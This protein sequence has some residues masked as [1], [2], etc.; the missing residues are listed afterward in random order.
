MSVFLKTRRTIG[1]T[2]ENKEL[3]NKLRAMQTLYARID[4]D[5]KVIEDFTKFLIESKERCDTLSEFYENEWQ[6]VVEEDDSR[7]EKGFPSLGI[8]VYK[9]SE[10]NGKYSILGEDTI[11]N[12]LVEHRY[13]LLDLL[14]TLVPMID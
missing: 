5:N 11:W 13:A 1:D 8:E 6:D 9:S 2:M 7:V 14:K 12:T 10:P 3:L 4:Q